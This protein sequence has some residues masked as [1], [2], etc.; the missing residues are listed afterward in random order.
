MSLFKSELLMALAAFDALVQH[1]LMNVGVNPLSTKL[2]LA[3]G[4][5]KAF[6]GAVVFF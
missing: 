6:A 1:V 4:I 3:S 5:N 2:P